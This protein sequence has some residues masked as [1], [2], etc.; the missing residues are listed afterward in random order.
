MCVLSWSQLNNNLLLAKRSSK[1]VETQFLNY[2]FT[3]YPIFRNK[4]R[5]DGEEFVI[6]NKGP[7]TSEKLT[8][9]DVDNFLDFCNANA[10]HILE[11]FRPNIVMEFVNKDAKK[12]AQVTR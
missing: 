3:L 11:K 5:V 6:Y 10:G 9:K 1:D 4:M 2:L 7:L 8:K 12:V